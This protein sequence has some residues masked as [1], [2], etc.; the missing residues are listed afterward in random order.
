MSHIAEGLLHEH[1]DGALESND[2]A[3]FSAE[4]HLEVCSDCRRRL[5]ETRELRETAGKILASADTVYGEAPALT[6]LVAEADARRGSSSGVPSAVGA[7]A[8]QATSAAGRPWW[9]SPAKLAWAAS[10]VL[11]LGAGWMGRALLVPPEGAPPA[12]E[13]T[14]TPDELEAAGQM[15]ADDAARRQAEPAPPAAPAEA[16][17]IGA[18]E[19]GAAAEAPDRERLEAA[20]PAAE[21]QAFAAKAA[22]APRCYTGAVARRPADL[23]LAPD[24]TARLRWEDTVYVGFWEPRESGEQALRLSDGG[25]WRELVLRPSGE[26]LRGTL[27]P[28][29]LGAAVSLAPEACSVD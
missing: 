17:A 7:P 15:L 20:A 27:A 26:S 28:E 9:R 6:D 3:W 14:R 16:D 11:A 21:T 29:T 22:E 19:E 10:L 2:P 1:L 12:A 5:E 24:G 8:S 4:T 23:R 18:N 13:V 25:A